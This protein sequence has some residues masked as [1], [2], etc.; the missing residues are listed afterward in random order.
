MAGKTLKSLKKAHEREINSVHSW[1]ALVKMLR[2]DEL[3]IVFSERDNCGIKQSYDDSLVIM[4]R[5]EEFNT[6]QVL[7]D[8]GRSTDIIYLPAL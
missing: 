1:L 5:I 2:N 3:D 6:H 7:I 4:L 8:N